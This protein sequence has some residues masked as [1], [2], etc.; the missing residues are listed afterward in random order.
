MQPSLK[1]IFAYKVTPLVRETVRRGINEERNGRRFGKR[2]FCKGKS[3]RTM[4]R[5]YVPTGCTP[6]NKAVVHAATSAAI[7][8]VGYTLPGHSGE[9]ENGIMGR[10][11]PSLLSRPPARIVWQPYW[12]NS[13][14]RRDWS[15][16]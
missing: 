16:F 2:D 7:K 5:G 10:D 13:Q 6:G 8:S 3:R 4:T 9:P 12:N 11:L 14:P 1:F 15:V